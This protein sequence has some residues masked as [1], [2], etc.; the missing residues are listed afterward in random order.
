MKSNLLLLGIA[1][2]V[3][4]Q[5]V[6]VGCGATNDGDP[7]DAVARAD[8]REL[9]TA[10][11]SAAVETVWTMA[12]DSGDDAQMDAAREELKRVVWKGGAPQALR[13]AAL[14]SLL[15]DTRPAGVADSAN[16][17]R[18][19]LPT[20]PQFGVLTLACEGIAKGAASGDPA[21]K[22]TASGLVRSWARKLPSPEDSQRPER[23]ALAAMFPLRSVEDTVFEVFLRPTDFGAKADSNEPQNGGPLLGGGLAAA[24]DAA[25]RVRSAAWDVLGRID[26]RGE[27]RAVLL[28]G[29]NLGSASSDPLMLGLQRSARELGVVPITG[30]EL[31]WLQTILDSKQPSIL[32]WWEQTRSAVSGLSSEQRSAL[33]LRHLEPVRWACVNQQAWCRA[34]SS[35]LRETLE[36]RLSAR[37]TY[38][39]GQSEGLDFDNN[40]NRPRDWESQLCWGD[41]LSILVLDEAIQ[42]PGVIAT[43]LKQAA[44]DEADE[45]TEWGGCLVDASHHSGRKPGFEAVIYQSRPAQR[46]NDRTFVA[47]NEMFTEPGA[48]SLAHY[49]FHAQTVRNDAYA[50][51]GKGDRD[52]ADLHNR[53]CMV[54]T[55]VRE[56]VL[57]AD[58]FQRGGATIDLGEVAVPK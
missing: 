12:Q 2:A 26:A 5:L 38:R 51:P 39:I 44:A 48:L 32:A 41:L 8:D 15:S 16:F 35:E 31:T 11:R 37:K 20:E 50:G 19:R 25:S 24:P 7:S 23:S 55:P 53:N 1:S 54:F 45:S 40:R 22:A 14:T 28:S 58:F 49:H 9:S 4:V 21:W 47:A 46:I 27:R 30:S 10:Q 36:A 18:L 3:L 29:E 13:E 52:Y 33:Q 56:G 57:N 17:L 43:L 42:S 6:F 34:T